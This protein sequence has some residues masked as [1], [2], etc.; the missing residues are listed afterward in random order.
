MKKLLLLLLIAPMIGNS[1]M[2]NL[3][4][5]DAIILWGGDEF[6]VPEGKILKAVSTQNQYNQ[7]SRFTGEYALAPLYSE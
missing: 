3:P 2:L 1:Q 4:V 6:T 5:S 7:V